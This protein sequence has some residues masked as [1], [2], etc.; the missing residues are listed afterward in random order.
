M[1]SAASRRVEELERELAKMRESEHYYERDI[2]D[3][4]SDLKKANAPTPPPLAVQP[5]TNIAPP[6]KT[7]EFSHLPP[8]MQQFARQAAAA[9]KLEID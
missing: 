4:R 1:N 6:P 5:V 2:K 9:R 3:L 8:A 7:D